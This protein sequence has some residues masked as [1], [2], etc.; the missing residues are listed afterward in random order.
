[1]GRPLDASYTEQCGPAAIA[2]EEVAARIKFKKED[3]SYRRG[4]FLAKGIG[5]SHRGGQTVSLAS[6]FLLNSIL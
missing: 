3:A 2:I 6:F 5:I 1:M 4:N